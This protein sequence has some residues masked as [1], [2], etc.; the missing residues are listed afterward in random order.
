MN[1]SIFPV[2]VIYKCEL[3]ECRT[4]KSLLRESDMAD[5]MVY[6]N[7][8]SSY[9]RPARLPQGAIY[10]RDT[11]NG[12]LSVA[13]NVA[14]ARARELGYKRLLL[15][16]QDTEFAPGTWDAY[17]EHADFDGITAPL[18]LTNHEALCSPTDVSGWCTRVHP[19][20]AGDYSLY[21]LNVIN[22]G[23]CVP[24]HLFERAGGYDL[25]VNLDFSDYQFQR[26]LRKVNDRLRLLPVV[27]HQDFSGDCRDYG[28]LIVRFR[29]YIKCAAH[30]STEGLA[31]SLGHHYTVWRH[32]AILTL[33]TQKMSFLKEY[34]LRF[35]LRRGLD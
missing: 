2:I 28:R 15:L 6:D 35:L 24:L 3:V 27:A 34:F 29:W 12:G 14:A 22:S 11:S 7:S 21:Q 5:F 30:F 26:R 20:S 19:V 23:M 8:P 10:L 9:S 25:R 33:K 4:Y 1:K 17:M 18:I 13:Y 16:D 31:D 32:T